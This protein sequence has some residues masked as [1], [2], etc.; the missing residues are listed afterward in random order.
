MRTPGA[1]HIVKLKKP[2]KN[3]YYTISWRQAGKQH[4]R[5]F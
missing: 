4:R 5:F 3:Y 1:P 2:Q